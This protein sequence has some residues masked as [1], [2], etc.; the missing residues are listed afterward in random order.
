MMEARVKR[1]LVAT[2][3]SARS[4]RALRRAGWLAEEAGSELVLLHVVDDRQAQRLID[5][6]VAESRKIVDTWITSRAVPQAVR[7]RSVISAGKPHMGI[8]EAAKGIDADLI[9]MGSHR[10]RFR[11]LFLGTTVERV[12]REASVPVLMVNTDEPYETIMIAADLS[13]ASAEAVTS[14]ARLGF[15]SMGQVAVVHAFDA[16]AKSKL[17]LAQAPKDRVSMYVKEEQQKALAKLKDFMRS[18]PQAPTGWTPYVEEGEAPYV[19]GTA[20]ERMSPGLLIL[21]TKGRTGAA[22]FLLGSVTEE[23]LGS[24]TVDV[25]AVPR[26]SQQRRDTVTRLPKPIWGTR[27]RTHK[28]FPN[29]LGRDSNSAKEDGSWPATTSLTSSGV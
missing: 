2:D 15:L 25:L 14:A 13:A 6:D 11:D 27:L 28:G 26:R 17:A 19:I 18:V 7:C 9:V 10:K 3:L 20:V 22:K 4:H 5:I 12:I 8:I 16:V 1:I 29:H 21:G 24:T 23:L